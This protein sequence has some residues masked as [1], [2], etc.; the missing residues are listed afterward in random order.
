MSTREPE[1][2]DALTKRE[3]EV[4]SEIIA[5]NTS[6]EGARHLDISFHTFERHRSRVFIKLGA[7]NAADMVRIVLTQRAAE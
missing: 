5:G 7:R 6:K 2:G 1:Y 3:G 4:M